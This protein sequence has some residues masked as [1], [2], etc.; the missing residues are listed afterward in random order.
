MGAR[1]TCV[2]IGAGR[3]I[4]RANYTEQRSETFGYDSFR[5]GQ[6]ELINAVMRGRA[7]PGI[8]SVDG[9]Q[10]SFL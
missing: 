7:V 9:G 4:E 2:I 8:M 3:L 5:P 1:R 6:E 10:V